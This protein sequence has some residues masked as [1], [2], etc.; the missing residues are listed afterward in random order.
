MEKLRRSG[1]GGGGER[2]R[3]GITRRTISTW[4]ESGCGESSVTVGGCFVDGSDVFDN[5][6]SSKRRRH[7]ESSD[8][9]FEASFL[10]GT[11]LGT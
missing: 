3:E 7:R 4:I 6:T 11:R 2:G 9:H 10:R 1:A 5:R 8:P